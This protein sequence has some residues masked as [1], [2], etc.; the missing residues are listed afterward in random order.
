MIMETETGVL[1]IQPKSKDAGNC[2]KLGERH[3]THSPFELARRN[4]PVH[5]LIWDFWSPERWENKFLWPWA[6]KFVVICY[7]SPRRLLQ[8]PSLSFLST[9][10]WPK[11]VTWSSQKSRAGRTCWSI[12]RPWQGCGYRKR[13]E[14]R[15]N[16]LMYPT[17]ESENFVF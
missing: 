12:E 11:P 5:T 15:G 17:W 3:R 7:G 1:L 16:Y 10:Y 4:Y 13:W 8:G 9:F 6:T 14:I 2:P